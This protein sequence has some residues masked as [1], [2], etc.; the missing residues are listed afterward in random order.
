M[1]RRSYAVGISVG[2]L[3]KKRDMSKKDIKEWFA[4][5]NAK[6][7]CDESCPFVEEC[8]RIISLSDEDATLCNI[9]GIEEEISEK[10]QK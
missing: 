4:T 6:D 7:N 1:D 3:M 8:N 10:Y 5:Q 9:L 2:Q